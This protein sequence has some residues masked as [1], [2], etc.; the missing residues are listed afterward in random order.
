MGKVSGCR[1]WLHGHLPDSAVR[2]LHR[3][4]VA[5]QLPSHSQHHAQ[6]R[7]HRT[8]LTPG[9]EEEEASRLSPARSGQT[10][11]GLDRILTDTQVCVCG[12]GGRGEWDGGRW[13]ANL[14]LPGL[15]HMSCLNVAL[16][17]VMNILCSQWARTVPFILTCLQPWILPHLL[18]RAATTFGQV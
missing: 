6:C 12:G 16:R 5:V 11:R 13:P 1:S 7:S 18:W 15:S 3:G 8:S 2:M 10:G 14:Q 17:L 4:R 9:C